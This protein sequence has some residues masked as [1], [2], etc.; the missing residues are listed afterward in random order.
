MELP[1]R[2]YNADLNVPGFQCEHEIFNHFD[3]V[4]CHRVTVYEVTSTLI[5]TGKPV[6]GQVIA[7]QF[8][9]LHSI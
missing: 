2:W 6:G 7:E 1:K 4:R 5:N 8:A 9:V 3:P